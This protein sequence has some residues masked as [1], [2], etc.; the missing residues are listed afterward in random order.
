MNSQVEEIVQL[1]KYGKKDTRKYKQVK[2]EDKSKVKR[3]TPV[4]DS[5]ER[6]KET[7]KKSIKR[8]RVDYLSE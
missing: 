4:A 7:V 1:L 3:V 6:A 8:K 5:L 2:K